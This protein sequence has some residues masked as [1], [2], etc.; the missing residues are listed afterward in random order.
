MSTCTLEVPTSKPSI[1]LDHLSFSSLRTYQACPRKF[2]FKNV[3][4]VPEEFTPSYFAFGGA[5]HRA[6]ELVHESMIVG[7]PVPGADELLNAYDHVW[8][9]L[10]AE[11]P[12]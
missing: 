12:R 5:F 2:A 3:D 4:G 9:G 8:S 1:R 11:K 6:V 10:V 7:A